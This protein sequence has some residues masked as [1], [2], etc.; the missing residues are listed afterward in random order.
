MSKDHN[1]RTLDKRTLDR[2]IEKG[3]IS[4]DEHDAY[5]KALPDLEGEMDNIADLIYGTAEEGDAAEASEPAAE[6]V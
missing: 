1:I 5:L 3:H 4:K 6:E 2:K